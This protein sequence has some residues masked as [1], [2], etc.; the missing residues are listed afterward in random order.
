MPSSATIPFFT[1][2]QCESAMP[3]LD[4][5]NNLEQGLKRFSNG[6]IEQPVRVMLPITEHSGFL[7]IM[8]CYS[9]ADNN[10][11]ACKL[12]SLYPKNT[13]LGIP[14]H[15]VYVLLFDASNGELKAVME[16]NSITKRR[17]AATSALSARWLAPKTPKV[18][19][20]LGSGHQGLAHM[21]V[22][23]NQYQDSIIKIR[24]W[25]HRKAG[26]VKLAEEV[27]G[28]LKPNQTIEVA[29]NVKDCVREAELIVTAT[30]ASEP[31][32]KA[33]DGLKQTNCHIMA[34]GAPRPDWAETDPEIWKESLVFVDSFAGAKTEAGDLIQS[35]CDVENELGAFINKG[36]T[37]FDH[38]DKRTAFKS[39]GLAIEDFVSAKMIFEN[40]EASSPWPVKFLEAEVVKK[41]SE[42]SLDKAS[43][44][45]SVSNNVTNLKCDGY[46]LDDQQTMVCDLNTSSTSLAVIYNAK[47]GELKGILDTTSIKDTSKEIINGFYTKFT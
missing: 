17:T 15:I 11:I 25:N 5:T 22:L 23:L 39:L 43:I 33:T 42:N 35:K 14:T 3:W 37:H 46:L 28:W 13:S 34:V 7:G 21:Q 38:S 12:V 27:S 19:A 20:I 8:P 45:R 44:L 31:V 1:N 6:E 10:L 2:L 26:A 41:M 18:L 47:T 32:M 24:I 29:E 16:G 40:V 4:L 30:F 9:K 36:E